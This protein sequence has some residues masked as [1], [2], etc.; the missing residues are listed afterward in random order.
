V[1]ARIAGFVR[2]HTYDRSNNDNTGNP[3]RS[4]APNVAWIAALWPHIVAAQVVSVENSHGD[5]SFFECPTGWM[6]RSEGRLGSNPGWP[7]PARPVVSDGKSN[8]KATRRDTRR[9]QF[10]RVASSESL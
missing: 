9:G 5:G 2:K 1:G 6:K 7:R 10:S 3:R 8:G 4:L